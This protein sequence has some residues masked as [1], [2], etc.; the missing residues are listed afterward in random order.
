MF[1]C[2]TFIFL[3]NEHIYSIDSRVWKRSVTTLQPLYVKTVSLL[4][5]PIIGRQRLISM[6]MGTA[7]TSNDL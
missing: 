5:D 3:Y 6:Q 2:N 4:R 1:I 7:I